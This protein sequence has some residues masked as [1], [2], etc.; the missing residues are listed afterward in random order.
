[1]VGRHSNVSKMDSVKAPSPPPHTH[2]QKMVVGG[3][4]G[5]GR[6]GMRCQC[7]TCTME[8]V[9]ECEKQ[10]WVLLQVVGI[11]KWF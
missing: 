11:T 4:G 7:H 9:E 6:G 1:M 5:G 2:T 3:G 10:R 8:G